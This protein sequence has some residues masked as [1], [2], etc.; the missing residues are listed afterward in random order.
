MDCFNLMAEELKNT[1][2]LEQQLFLRHPPHQ[3]LLPKHVFYFKRKM[4][5]RDRTYSQLTGSILVCFLYVLH[6]CNLEFIFTGLLVGS[7][8][9]NIEEC[10]E[11]TVDWEYLLDL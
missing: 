1:A 3:I 8:S 11:G 6:V 4:K 7:F 2:D 5:D 10:V 9:D